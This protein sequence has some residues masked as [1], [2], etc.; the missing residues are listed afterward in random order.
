MFC[1]SFVQFHTY[2]HVNNSLGYDLTHTPVSFQKAER[3]SVAIARPNHT[4]DNAR[5]VLALNPQSG[6]LKPNSG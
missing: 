6:Y 2:T 5:L 3:L 4:Q 1:F